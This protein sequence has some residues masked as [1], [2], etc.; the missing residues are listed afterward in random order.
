[1]SIRLISMML[2]LGALVAIP[3][4]S[5]EDDGGLPCTIE[6]YHP[7]LAQL[8]CPLKGGKV[9]WVNTYLDHVPGE[10]E[11]GDVITFQRP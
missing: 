5:C 9:M 11:I 6:K 2:F 8:R 1:M 4:S 7:P 3:I 10:H